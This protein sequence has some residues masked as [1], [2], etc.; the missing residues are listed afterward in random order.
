MSVHIPSEFAGLPELG[1]H[2]VSLQ[3]FFTIQS[4]IGLVHL[5]GFHLPRA[6]QQLFLLDICCWLVV[7]CKKVCV[8]FG[9]HKKR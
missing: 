4:S 1:L 3:R 2:F 9:E 6:L 5:L 7:E 8:T